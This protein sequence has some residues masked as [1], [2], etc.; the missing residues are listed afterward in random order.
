MDVADEARFCL[1]K[2]MVMFYYERAGFKR[3]F[4]EINGIHIHGLKH[5]VRASPRNERF[6]GVQ[7]SGHGAI[8]RRKSGAVE[9]QNLQ[10][11][12][13]TD[14]GVPHTR[15]G[16]TAH[17]GGASRRSPW[18]PRYHADSPHVPTRS[19]GLGGEQLTVGVHRFE[20]GAVACPSAETWRCGGASAARP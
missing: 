2:L 10:K 3:E 19:P 9:R 18:A 6:W 8:Y 16:D 4:L 20:D 17:A 13:P 14:A 15:R 11:H 7:R 1:R 12:R 5:S